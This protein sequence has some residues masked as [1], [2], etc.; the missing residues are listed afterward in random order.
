MN[1]SLRKASSHDL[2]AV[3]GLIQELATYERAPQEVTVTLEELER[4]GFGP[5]PIFEIILAEQGNELA[6]MAFFYTAYS[7]WK[8]KCV[9]LED[10]IVPE[11][12]RGKGIGRLLFNAVVLRAKEMQAK[13]LMWQVLDW[14]ETAINFYKKY[15]ALLD[16]TWVNGRL[17]M[18]QIRDFK[19]LV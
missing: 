3:L 7:T 5:Q 2:P 9:Y 6:G 13:R 16:P 11:A 8:G 10:I 18:E 19:P 1:I 17:T 15:D 4:D 14:N 12:L